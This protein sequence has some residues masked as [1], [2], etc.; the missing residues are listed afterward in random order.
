LFIGQRRLEKSTPAEAVWTNRTAV[1]FNNLVGIAGPNP[2]TWSFIVGC[3]QTALPATLRHIATAC[4][5]QEAD[6]A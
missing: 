1:P 5:P 2:N 3:R 6:R 4:G